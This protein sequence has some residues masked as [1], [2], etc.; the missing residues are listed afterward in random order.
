MNPKP[1][2]RI[3]LSTTGWEPQVWIEQFRQLTERE[4]VTESDGPNDPSIRYAVVW[5]QKPGVLAAL[6]NLQAI[7]SI[8]AGVDHILRDPSVPHLPVV[9]VVAGDLTMRM[10][11][12][13]VWQVL[14][15]LRH[16]QVYREQQ[17]RKIWREPA[18]P[19]ASDLTIG[20]MGLGVL[21]S[22]AGRKLAMLGFNV[23]GWSRNEKHVAGIANYFGET[24]LPVFAG[25]CDMLVVLLPLTPATRGI[26][27]KDLLGYLRQVT[28]LGGPVLINAGRGQLQVDA[29][30]LEALQSRTLMAASLDVFETEPLPRDSALWSHPRVMVT[31]HAAATSDPARLAPI[32]VQQM[33]DHDAG[34][35]FANLVDR[36]AG[37]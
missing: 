26:I 18:Q 23:I 36:E 12:Y 25:A 4:V 24:Q 1:A 11:E 10:S 6:P 37:Y 14:D 35:P 2:N 15:H 19:A 5:K 21:G 28:P 22:D 7:F 20:I 3:L 33:D 16:G 29:D 13:V 34:L 31:P 17:A 8:G 30:I 27:N 9:R 32:M